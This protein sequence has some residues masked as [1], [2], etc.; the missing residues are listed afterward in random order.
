MFTLF[1]LLSKKAFA[2]VPDW[3]GSLPGSLP[4]SGPYAEVRSGVVALLDIAL[5]LVGLFTAIIIVMAGIR[6][7]SSQGDD[8][9]KE[10][11]KNIIFYAAIGLLI[12]LFAKA[13]VTFF[14]ALS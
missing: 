6:L 13:I 1:S 11:A 14:T 2:Q 7:I 5:N 8:T 12:I 3:G 9:A 4:G 10:K